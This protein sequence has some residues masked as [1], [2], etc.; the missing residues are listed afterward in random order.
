MTAEIIKRMGR[1]KDVSQV[2]IEQVLS[3]AKRIEAQWLHKAILESIKEKSV[4]MMRKNQN[5]EKTKC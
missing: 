1:L 3:L 2:T 5:Q 4:D